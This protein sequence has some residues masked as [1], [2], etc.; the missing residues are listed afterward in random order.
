MDAV[1]K[2]AEISGTLDQEGNGVDPFDSLIAGIALAHGVESLVTRNTSHF[3]RIKGL[4]T[5]TH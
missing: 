3:N 2:A 5:E 4:T 1:K